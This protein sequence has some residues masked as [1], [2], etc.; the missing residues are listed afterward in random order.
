MFALLPVTVLVS[1]YLQRFAGRQR[2]RGRAS[3]S[4][5]TASW[6][7]SPPPCPAGSPRGSRQRTLMVIGLACACAGV[8]LLSGTSPGTTAF[9]L[10][11]GAAAHRRGRRHRAARRDLDRR[12][13]RPVDRAGMAAA[14][15]NAG[16]QLG[17]TLGIAVLGSIVLAGAGDESAQAFCDDLHV[18]MLVG[19][20]ALASAGVLTL[21]AIRPRP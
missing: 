21:V 15:H 12:R 2:A 11:P 19:A 1:A 16:R 9:D 17:A 18:A 13:R 20:A 7:R 4:R 5:P 10:A 6:S 14:I 8:A 3:R